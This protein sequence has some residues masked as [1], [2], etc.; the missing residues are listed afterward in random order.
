VKPVAFAYEAPATVADALTLLA[1]HGDE[2]KAL[3][4]GQ[5]LVPLLN[6]R[7]A[8]PAVVVDLNRL[9]RELAGL[10][11]REGALHIGAL[12]RTAALER[13]PVVTAGWPVLAECARHIGH[14]Q[15]RNRGTVGGSVAHADPAAELPVVL[16]A[17]GARFRLRSARAERT[18]AAGELFRGYLETALA[19]DELLVGID[20]PPLPPRTGTAFC[21]W[22]RLHG[23]FAL[24]GA[25]AVVTLDASGRCRKAALALLGAGPTPLRATAAE[26]ALRS[27]RLDAGT[28]AEAADAAAD[29]ASPPGQ[30]RSHR[31]ALLRV[32]A[33]RA[34]LA[35]AAR[36]EAV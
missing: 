13:S 23:D 10:R 6:F 9:G 34:L 3:A 32:V 8:R 1:R 4:G 17:L 21:E 36:A 12:T 26:A 29:D 30:H 14:P 2:A 25:A 18:L 22:S 27:R 35:A 20:V 11:R 5:S 33:R 15:I 16:A 24:A 19:P 31:R 7:L 28:A